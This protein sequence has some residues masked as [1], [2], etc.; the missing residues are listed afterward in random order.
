MNQPPPE[1]IGL[2]RIGSQGLWYIG[3]TLIQ[4]SVSLLM[5]PVYTRF[6][7]PADYGVIQ[8]L[9]L[10]FDVLSIIAGSRLA[11]GVF[12]FYHKAETESERRLVLS[13]A[14]LLT[15][16]LA[17]AVGLAALAAAPILDRLVFG[18]DRHAELFR[19]YAVAFALSLTQTVPWAWLRLAERPRAMVGYGLFRTALQV[20]CNVVFLTGGLGVKG[21]VL[22]NVIATAVLTIP[23]CA[24]V[25]RRAGLGV[26]RVWI[27]RHLRF[28]L[29]LVA[30]Q[31][32]TFVL[33]YG[34]RY[35]L[36][37]HGGE[38][39]VGLYSLS[40]QF[41]FLMSQVAYWPFANV[42]EPVRFAI[43]K[44]DN[45]DAIFA[46]AFLFVNVGL[47]TFAVGISLF[48]GD[49]LR[50]MTTPGFHAA[51]DIVP[52]I[53]LAYLFQSWYSM[54]DIGLHISEQTRYITLANWLSGAVVLA[55]YALLIPPLGA[56]GA[57]LATLI[58]F[59]MRWALIYRYSQRLWPVRY[60]WAPVR[61]LLLGAGV[62]VAVAWVLP[63]MRLVP[64]VLVRTGL[65]SFYAVFTLYGGVISAED[66]ALLLQHP[67]NLVATL[68]R[69][70]GLIR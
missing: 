36:R 13:S 28:S 24:I 18:A 40:Y 27:E 17:V 14:F 25:I 19:Y 3:G 10:T 33:T 41:G 48:V 35:F 29:P 1:R 31:V 34:D 68:R 65:F 12:T 42:W 61:R 20:T 55:G 57:A 7:T 45:R 54:Q 39:V 63:T 50:V 62:L 66:R 32:A 70:L 53:L 43:A 5:L 69:T 67:A 6:L 56:L 21:M 11:A 52:L 38:A 44:Q 16:G 22:G 59:A 64:S 30:T 4:R 46:R 51:A 15:A 60:E 9:E 23:L 58:S 37:V 47:V 8:L 26:N 49:V 2:R